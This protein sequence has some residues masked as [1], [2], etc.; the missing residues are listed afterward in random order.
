M[1]GN[2][3]VAT[4]TVGM[5]S[6]VRQRM[7]PVTS[8]ALPQLARYSAALVGSMSL[9]NT[10]ETPTD[11]RPARTNPT[12]AK[13]SA[14]LTPPPAHVWKPS[15][16][17][18]SAVLVRA[19]KRLRQPRHRNRCARCAAPSCTSSWSQC[20]HRTPSGQRRVT[21]QPSAVLSS[22]NIVNN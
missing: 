15:F 18:A 12:P 16:E 9:A 13:N 22:G 3:A 2:D 7:S 19:K 17:S 20:G 10:V 5:S 11:S 14:A 1:H 4:S 8:S 21:K 6:P